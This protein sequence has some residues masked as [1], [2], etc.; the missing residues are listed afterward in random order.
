MFSFLCC[1]I[2]G[3]ELSVP[4]SI[5]KLLPAQYR[6]RHNVQDLAV[7]CQRNSVCASDIQNFS[8]QLELLKS[9]G[10]DIF[11]ILD[12]LGLAIEQVKNDVDK[13][14]NNGSCST[15]TYLQCKDCCQMPLS[16][17]PSRHH[18]CHIVY[19]LHCPSLLSF[20]GHL[21]PSFTYCCILLLWMC[22]SSF[23]LQ[24]C[25]ILFACF[26]FVTMIKSI[27]CWV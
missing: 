7:K 10:K 12:I 20:L 11:R 13:E 27:E 24:E 1:S 17:S 3:R 9:K 26:M 23:N 19:D 14:C 22:I 4:S 5:S 18:R 6:L 21:C 25:D 16:P 2:L 15:S 8:S